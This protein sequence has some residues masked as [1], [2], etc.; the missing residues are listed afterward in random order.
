[1]VPVDAPSLANLHKTATDDFG[2]K[3]LHSQSAFT[4]RCHFDQKIQAEKTGAAGSLRFCGLKE[5][6]KTHYSTAANS[7]G[8]Y[9]VTGSPSSMSFPGK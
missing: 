2:L 6:S 1:M 8:S 9:A 7:S 3:A 4:Y 5:T